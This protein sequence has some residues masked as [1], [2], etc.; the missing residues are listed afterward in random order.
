VAG[1][2][3]SVSFASPATV[4]PAI[5][6]S[7]AITAPTVTPSVT[8]ITLAA[9]VTAVT[10]AGI[11]GFFGIVGMTAICAAALPIIIMV[12]VFEAA[13]LVTGHGWHGTGALRRYCSAY[14]SPSWC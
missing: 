1:D 14:R 4:T 8:P 10:P 2:G 5:T 7:P 6:V 13:K 9:L 11:S 12:G 3:A